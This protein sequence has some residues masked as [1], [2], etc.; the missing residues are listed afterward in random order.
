M[1]QG[2][3][4]ILECLW[5][6]VQGPY[7]RVHTPHHTDHVP[8]EVQRLVLE[9]LASLDVAVVVVPEVLV[10]D[11]KLLPHPRFWVHSEVVVDD[12]DRLVVPDGVVESFEHQ[13]VRDLSVAVEE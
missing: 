2:P 13:S 1:I 3:E 12:L 7:V 10:L 4:Q 6:P 9:H 8:C 11:H 5:K